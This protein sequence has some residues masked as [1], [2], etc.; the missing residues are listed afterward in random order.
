VRYQLRHAP[1][2]PWE[3]IG[4][5]VLFLAITLAF[6]A[7]ALYCATSGQWVLALAGAALALWMASLAWAALRKM[8]S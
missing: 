6:A 5:A 1:R 8:R 4:V 2:L 3:C 7:I